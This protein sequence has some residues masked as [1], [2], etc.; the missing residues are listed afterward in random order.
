MEPLSEAEKE[1]YLQILHKLESQAD[2]LESRLEADA[3][4]ERKQ[5]EQKQ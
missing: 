5:S 3:A 2:L 4:K 1:S